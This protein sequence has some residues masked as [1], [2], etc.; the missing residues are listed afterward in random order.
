MSVLTPEENAGKVRWYSHVFRT[1]F[2]DDSVPTW[3]VDNLIYNMRD[4]N[5]TDTY[6]KKMI[7]IRKYKKNIFIDP[8]NYICTTFKVS[9]LK[10]K[11]EANYA[12]L[13]SCDTKKYNKYNETRAPAILSPLKIFYC[14]SPSLLSQDG[15]Y[16][17][18]FLFYIRFSNFLN[19]NRKLF[20]VIEKIMIHKIEKDD[21]SLEYEHFFPQVEF[22]YLGESLDNQIINDNLLMIFFGVFWLL[23]IHNIKLGLQENHINPKFNQLFFSHLADDMKEYDAIVKRFGVAYINNVIEELYYPGYRQFNVNK[24]IISSK[25]MMGQKLRPLNVGE[26]QKPF[27]ILY[28][29]WREMYLHILTNSLLV[30]YICPSFAVFVDWIYIKNSKKGLFDNE[31][32]Y[33]KLDYSERALAITRKLREAQRVTYLREKKSKK[34]LNTLFETL[35]DKI[36]DP[37]EYVK[38][39]LLMSNVTLGFIT[40]NVGRTFYDLPYLSK[41][42]YWTDAVGDLLNRY[43]IFSKYI[44]DICY[45][46]L[47]INVKLGMTHSDLHLNNVTINDLDGLAKSK[48]PTVMY[49]VMGYWFKFPT[50]GPYAYIIDFSRGTIHPRNIEKYPHF[51]NRDEYEKFIFDQNIRMIEA[52]EASFPTFVKIHFEKI[53]DM[54]ENNFDKFYMLYSAIDIYNFCS[55]LGKYLADNKTISENLS[56]LNKIVKIAERI[57]TVMMLKLIN[58]PDLEIE[59]PL[60]TIMKECFSENIVPTGQKNDGDDIIDIWTLDKPLKYGLDKYESWNPIMSAPH[61]IDVKYD[62]KSIKPLK[63]LL[64]LDTLRVNYEKYRKSQMSMINYIARRHIEK[65]K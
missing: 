54:I 62:P 10:L 6:L 41:I 49:Q 39:F 2:I 11:I 43:E 35:N 48:N 27:N 58:N 31:Q 25:Q 15:E 12:F 22:E 60:F 14:V 24:N 53:R 23:E 52:Y 56:L 55:K 32:Q 59:W 61:T 29:P 26:V 42:K 13:Y 33:Q 64:I 34:F 57:L 37:V 36:E 28:D 46:I 4:E 5:N 30:N 19:E 63:K 17:N 45:A 47:C 38:S 44:W 9:S 7:K 3:M 65:Y 21:L 8:V 51:K 18:K 16:R 20:E 40:E 1:E 50:K